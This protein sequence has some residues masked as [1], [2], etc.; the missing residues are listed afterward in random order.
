MIRSEQHHTQGQA[1]VEALSVTA[2][3]VAEGV[4]PISLDDEA[5]VDCLLD[6]L[7]ASLAEGATAEVV[8]DVA[9]GPSPRG[10]E[11]SHLRIVGRPVPI[12]A[13]TFDFVL[14]SRDR[15]GEPGPARHGVDPAAATP[16]EAVVQALD[17]PVAGRPA[18]AP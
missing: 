5:V 13:G 15:R 10:A 9:I 1:L 14:V 17:E 11:V 2:G 6:G 8:E 4:E 3:I 18:L 16:L 7:R 12:G